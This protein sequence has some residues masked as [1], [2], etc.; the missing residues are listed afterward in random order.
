MT[1]RLFRRRPRH[2]RKRSRCVCRTSL[3]IGEFFNQTY[4]PPVSPPAG[5][6]QP[7]TEYIAK[8]SFI[9]DPAPIRPGLDVSVSPDSGDGS[10]MSWVDLL[11]T[12]DGVQVT[13]SDSSGADVAISSPMTLELLSPW[14]PHTIEFRI[15]L[16]PGEAND[17]VRIVIDGQRRRSVLHDL[18]EL[19]PGL[20]GT[21]KPPNGNKPPNI[22]SLQFRSS[23]PRRSIVPDGG[24]LFDN[25]T[26]TTGTGPDSP[27]CDVTIDK[28]ADASTVLPAASRATR[29]P[30]ATAAVPVA[31]NVQ[32][33]DRIPRGMTFVRADRKLQRVGRKRCLV[34]PQP[35]ARPTRERPRHAPRRCGP[36]RR[37]G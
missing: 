1:R 25:V 27:G 31:R 22:N 4:S 20:S 15:K 21:G 16:I 18:G 11:D 34:I 23:V 32:V 8:F 3:R 17:L 9:Q 35:R 13:A 36:R 10:R 6:N 14:S 2:L 33:C 26:V 30:P 29:S 24:Y 7:N 37:A 5:E 28:Q 19:L 12:P